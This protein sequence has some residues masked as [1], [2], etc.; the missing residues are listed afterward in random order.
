MSDTFM[1]AL[2]HSRLLA[3][4]FFEQH[5]SMYEI[6]HVITG[7]VQHHDPF[8]TNAVSK[9]IELSGVFVVEPSGI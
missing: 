5:L 7:S 3:T 1:K 2:S 9:L 4:K 6:D 8:T